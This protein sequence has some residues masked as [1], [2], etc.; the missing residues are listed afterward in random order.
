MLKLHRTTDTPILNSLSW[1]VY[2]KQ[3]LSQMYPFLCLNTTHGHAFSGGIVELR[4]QVWS[5][6][7]EELYLQK[8]P[9]LV[10]PWDKENDKLNCR[11]TSNNNSDIQ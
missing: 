5:V 4:F 11:T 9:D 1:Y 2:A 10:R 6:E 7:K 3:L 8:S